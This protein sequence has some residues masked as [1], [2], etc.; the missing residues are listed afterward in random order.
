MCIVLENNY[1]HNSFYYTGQYVGLY[2]TQNVDDNFLGKK[3]CK[4]WFICIIIIHTIDYCL[5][6]LSKLSYLRTY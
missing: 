3:T 5:A 2:K 6:D 4:Y 1:I